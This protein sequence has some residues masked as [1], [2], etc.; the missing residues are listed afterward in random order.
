MPGISTVF[1]NRSRL[2]SYQVLIFFLSL[3]IIFCFNHS[4]IIQ[5]SSD[6]YC[7]TE[8]LEWMGN[9]NIARVNGLLFGASSTSSL[10]E[11]GIINR[12]PKTP[13][14]QFRAYNLPHLI[15]F[16]SIFRAPIF[17]SYFL[18]PQ[19]PRILIKLLSLRLAIF[20]RLIIHAMDGAY[21]QAWEHSQ[22]LSLAFPQF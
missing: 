15:P 2:Y 9:V 19:C 12:W 17:S 14:K 5:L 4:L 8:S 1:S 13:E 22:V 20:I 18:L 6:L 10:L 3:T 7:S 16:H 11:N 21:V